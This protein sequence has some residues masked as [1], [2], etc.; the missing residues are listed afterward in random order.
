MEPFARTIDAAKKYVMSSTLD[1]VDWSAKLVRADLRQPEA[2]PNLV[3]VP[4][5]C[6]ALFIVRCAPDSNC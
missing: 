4:S 6:P 5:E 2:P 1:R 3:H